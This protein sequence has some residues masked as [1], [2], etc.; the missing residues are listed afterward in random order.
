MPVPPRINPW[1]PAP[2]FPCPRNFRVRRRQRVRW[3]SWS[4]H[5]RD[6]CYINRFIV[7]HVGSDRTRP[8]HDIAGPKDRVLHCQVLWFRGYCRDSIIHLLAPASEALR[9]PCL[10]PDSRIPQ[11]PWPEGICLMSIFAMF[12]VELLAIRSNL[13]GAR[14]RRCL[15]HGVLAGRQDPR[16]GFVRH[17]GPALGR[18]DRRV[19]ADAR[20]A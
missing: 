16:V 10:D 3:T 6:L 11:Y 18:G 17:D 15:G 8:V 12:F 14:G 20:G 7:G 1:R 19:P 4:A 2:D 13:V 9:S 5:L